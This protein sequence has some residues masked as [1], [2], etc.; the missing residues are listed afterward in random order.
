M[1]SLHRRHTQ[2]FSQRESACHVKIEELDNS[3]HEPTLKSKYVV[4][5]ML[6]EY[7]GRKIIDQQGDCVDD[8]FVNEAAPAHL[9]RKYLEL[10]CQEVALDASV[11]LVEM[12]GGHFTIASAKLA[13]Y[14]DNLYPQDFYP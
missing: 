8:F 14:I 5:G 11:E 7:M 1:L 6:E 3:I 10:M 9:M 12:E 13:K 2:T 4:L